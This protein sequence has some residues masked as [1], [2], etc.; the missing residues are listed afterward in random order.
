MT[1]EE[2]HRGTAKMKEIEEIV[3]DWRFHKISPKEAIELLR[4]KIVRE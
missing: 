2:W 3:W 4:K 1:S